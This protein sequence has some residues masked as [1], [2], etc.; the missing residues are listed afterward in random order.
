MRLL[1]SLHA[2]FVLGLAKLSI[3]RTGARNSRRTGC[4]LY[5]GVEAI[6]RRDPAV[7]RAGGGKAKG[8]VRTPGPPRGKPTHKGA[9]RSTKRSSTPGAARKASDL[10][11]D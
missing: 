7:R 10:F 4:K 11:G 3:D 9:V 8:I 5:A 1:A 2:L 6:L